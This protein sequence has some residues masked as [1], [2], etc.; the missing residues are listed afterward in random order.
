MMRVSLCPCAH[1]TT[2]H[3]LARMFPIND[4]WAANGL[5]M[6]VVLW[7]ELSGNFMQGQGRAGLDRE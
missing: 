7:C 4:G 6:P 3:V 2:C 5:I 1:V